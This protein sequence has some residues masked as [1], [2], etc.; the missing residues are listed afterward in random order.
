M[1]T[2]PPEEAPAAVLTTSPPWVDSELDSEFME[3]DEE[4]TCARRRRYRADRDAVAP[5]SPISRPRITTKGR[6]SASKYVASSIAR[7]CSN[8]QLTNLSNHQGEN[9]TKKREAENKCQRRGMDLLG[10][11]KTGK[12]NPQQGWIRV[13]VTAPSL[14]DS[15]PSPS[16]QRMLFSLRYCTVI[17]FK[18][19]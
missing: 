2:P 14:Q 18:I 11:T 8:T 19:R 16:F 15:S 9:G 4:D 17:L 6:P 1:A 3:E 7:E 5:C 12:R 10:K 13:R